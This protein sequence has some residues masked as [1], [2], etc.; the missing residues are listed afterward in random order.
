MLFTVI[1]IHQKLVNETTTHLPITTA[2]PTTNR[3]KIGYHTNQSNCSQLIFAKYQLTELNQA[4]CSSPPFTNSVKSAESV[5]IDIPRSSQAVCLSPFF[6][7]HQRFFWCVA[8]VNSQRVCERVS[9]SV[10]D[11]VDKCLCGPNIAF[12]FGRKICFRPQK[13]RQ[14]NCSKQRQLPTIF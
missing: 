9:I 4:V 12:A 13:N 14:I 6:S 3:H 10:T 5:E 1:E 8:V 2:V 7:A 11:R